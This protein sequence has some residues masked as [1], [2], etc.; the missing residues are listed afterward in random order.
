MATKNIQ[1][2]VCPIKPQHNPET[3]DRNLPENTR[4]NRKK[5]CRANPT[6]GADNKNRK[7][8]TGR[9]KADVANP[10]A[11]RLWARRQ[12]NGKPDMAARNGKRPDYPYKMGKPQKPDS[13]HLKTTAAT[14]HK[15][16]TKAA[17]QQATEL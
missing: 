1:S 6:Q 12:L 7:T 8:K 16:Q 13:P 17:C 11:G 2:M 10:T 14:T 5:A 4:S 3:P 15:I 9:W